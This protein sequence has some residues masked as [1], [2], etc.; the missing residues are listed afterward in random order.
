MRKMKDSGIEWIGEI[1][2]EWEVGKVKDYYKLQ[3]GFTPDTKKQFY[4][5]DEEGY[6]WVTI[7][8][9]SNEKFVFD[10]K[11]KISQIYIDEKNPEII[12]KGSLLYSFKLSVGQVAFAGKD[13]YSNEAIA[14]F[15]NNDNCNLKFLYYSSFMIIENA[16]E[17]IYG[18]KLLNQNLINNA[19]II[20][21]PLE[22]QELIADYLDNKVKE[23]DN[24]ISK[25][26]ETIE[27]YKKYKQS[28][29]T[30]SVTKGL[31]PN[32]EMKDSGIEWIGKIPKHWRIVKM[33]YLGELDS[34]GVDKKIRDNEPLYK[35]IH[36]TNVYKGS[37]S[38]IGN[39]DDYLVISS[40]K[41]KALRCMLRKGDV[42]FTN[43]SE[44]PDDM[45]HSTVIKEDL[46]DTLFGYHLMR[47]RPKVNICLKY[48]KYLFGAKYMRTWFEY[49][50]NGITRFGINRDVFTNALVLLP[51]LEEQQA[52][53][54]YLD[55]KCNEINNLTAKKQ[56][57]ITQL[58]KYKKSLIYECVTGKK[59]V[60]QMAYTY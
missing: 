41:E 47:F 51:P 32:V 54:N 28:V 21:P 43:S 40:S 42:L 18:A 46:T 49:C 2:E 36:Y 31:N 34:A 17:N 38:E 8:D 45:G 24:I 59:A 57:L 52:I 27:E 12:P 39:C 4:Y 37:L 1:P 15:L 55:K 60:V 35:S 48:E 3:T 13:I 9:L 7:S 22:E 14:S 26:Q 23:I 53:A 20:F 58:E 5:D 25:T 56:E 6:D 44:T 19:Y 30:E 33:R 11:N 16:N 10:T 29:I 50:S